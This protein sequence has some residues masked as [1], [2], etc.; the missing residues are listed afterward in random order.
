MKVRARLAKEGRARF[1]SHLDLQST[2]ER[3]LRRA[4]IP[5]AYTQGFNPHPRFSFASALATGSSSEGEFMDVELQESMAPEVFAEQINQFFPPGVRVLE[6][7]QAPERG[8]SLFS[9]IDAAAYRISVRGAASGLLAAAVA[10]FLGRDVVEMEKETKRGKRMVNMREQVFELAAQT[11]DL[12]HAVVQSGP[13]GNLKP[14][15]LFAGMQ[16]VYPALAGAE[17][18][19]AH[20]LMLY[21]RDPASGRLLPPWDL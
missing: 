1:L 8:D 19:V 18:A 14:D 12:L 17:L 7:R 2:L 16:A 11:D 6:A 3:T 10:A 20:R 9:M 15:D 4:R 21:R 13:Q 5:V